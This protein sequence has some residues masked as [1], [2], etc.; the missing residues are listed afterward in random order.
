MKL[1]RIQ[2]DTFMSAMIQSFDGQLAALRQEL[3]GFLG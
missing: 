2:P 3:A 1:D